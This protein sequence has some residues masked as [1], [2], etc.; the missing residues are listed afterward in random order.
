M[1][2]GRAYKAQNRKL[3]SCR[4][5]RWQPKHSQFHNR[6]PATTQGHCCSRLGAQLLSK[7]LWIHSWEHHLVL[8]FLRV[9]PVSEVTPTAY[10]HA[11][12]FWSEYC[13]EGHFHSFSSAWNIKPVLQNCVLGPASAQMGWNEQ[14]SQDAGEGEESCCP[15]SKYKHYQIS[16]KKKQPR[17]I[18]GAQSDKRVAPVCPFG[19][20]WRNVQWG[21][22]QGKKRTRAP[23]QGQKNLHGERT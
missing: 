12:M 13:N 14:P 22:C 11:N 5:L 10:T 7:L 19:L 23:R 17:K 16:Q 9:Q 20:R 15:E 8:C 3:K 4:H 21:W 6:N 1:I 2:Q 18:E